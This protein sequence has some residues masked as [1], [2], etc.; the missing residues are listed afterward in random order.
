M[1]EILHSRAHIRSAVR[2]LADVLEIEQAPW[3]QNMPAHNTYD[4]LCQACESH[5]DRMA[6]RF[7]MKGEPAAP[8]SS[9]TYRELRWRVTQAANAF[10]RAGIL[11]GKAV[12]LLMPNLPQTHYA[13]LGAQAAGI[14]SPIN[15]MLEAEHIAGIINETGAEALV[16]LAPLP[17]TDIWDK[18]MDVVDRCPGIRVVFA[19]SSRQYLDQP[20]EALIEDM[21]AKSRKPKRN[22]VAILDFDTALDAEESDRLVSAREFDEFD[23]CSYFHT[24]GTTGFPKIAAHTHLNETFIAWTLGAILPADN[25]LLC[26]L[27]LFHVNGA[28]VTGLAAFHSGAEVVML[29]PSGYRGQGVLHNFWKLVERFKAT[30]FSAVPTI[31]AAL[32]DLPIGDADISTLRYAVCGAAPLPSEVARR[33]ESA[34]GIQLFEGYGLTEGACVSSCNPPLGERRFGTVGIRLPHQQI[35]VWKIDSNGN[36]TEEC[37]GGEVGV[38]GICGPNVFPGYLR[39]LDNQGIWLR[40]GWLNTGD[41]GYF[42]EDGYLH[43]TGRAKELIIRGGHNIDPAMIED[44]LLKVPFVTAVAAVGQPDVHAGELPVAY[45]TIK[46]GYIANTDDLLVVARELIPERAAIPVRIEILEKMPLTAIG[47][48][49]KAELRLRAAEH[50]FQQLLAAHDIPAKIQVRTDLRRGTTAF[51]ECV[52]ENS[53]QVH[54]L[55]GNFAIPVELSPLGQ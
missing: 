25:V 30:S 3:H 45:V 33:F 22:D 31:Y 11:K 14:A 37:N 15:P 36:A 28:M 21:F 16:A 55:L 4:L 41:L 40:P 19:A 2:S 43:L 44:V 6:L 27:P 35:K 8:E 13:L 1:S 54:E 32:A 52:V 29:T 38:I 49:A 39:H 20:E 26:G 9:I 53:P 47:K 10:H 18:A 24:G 5:A 17:G 46:P 42:D 48:V 51:I 12:S 7:V 50:V 34:S 23:V